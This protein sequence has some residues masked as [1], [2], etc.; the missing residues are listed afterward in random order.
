MHWLCLHC[1]AI[2]LAALGK[3]Q[4]VLQSWLLC[5]H[6]NCLERTRLSW[7]SAVAFTGE[8][9][10]TKQFNA[11]PAVDLPNIWQKLL[12]KILT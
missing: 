5:M 2:P 7:G 1:L 8:D 6:A 11:K 9:S 12:N 4:T 10:A 3:H